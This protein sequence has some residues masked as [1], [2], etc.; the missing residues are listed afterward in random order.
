MF[1]KLAICV[2]ASIPFVGAIVAM[3]QGW[4]TPYGNPGVY[5]AAVVIGLVPVVVGS[6][7]LTRLAIRIDERT[8][9]G[10]KVLY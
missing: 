1:K 4:V 3:A 5:S 7:A 10:S 2:G 6:L 8:G 9:R